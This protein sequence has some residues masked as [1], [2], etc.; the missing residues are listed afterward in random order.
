[1]NRKQLLIL[2]AA[3]GLFP[4]LTVAQHSNLLIGS[5]AGDSSSSTFESHDDTGALLAQGTLD[6]PR[7][8]HSATL[9]TNGFIF[10]A[11]GAEDPTSWEIFNSSG[12]VQG[13]GITLNGLSGHFA[14]R[15]GNGNVFLGGGA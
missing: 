3:V 1:M 12:K 5:E 15:L 8:N 2:I 10:V 11:G 4:T 7:S 6:V 13:S 9:L 14:V